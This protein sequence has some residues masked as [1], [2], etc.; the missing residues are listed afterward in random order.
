MTIGVRP[1]RPLFALK[2]AALLLALGAGLAGGA[3]ALQQPAAA[4]QSGPAEDRRWSALW[5]AAPDA[6]PTGAGVYFFRRDIELGGKPSTFP[7]RLSADNRYRLVV[8]GEFVAEGPARGDLLNWNYETL[9]LARHLRSGRNAIAVTVWNFGDLKPA[10]QFSLRTGLLM[11]GLDETSKEVNS[12]TGWKVRTDRAYSFTRVAEADAGGFYVAGPG[13]TIDAAAYPW[14]WETAELSGPGW[15]AAT[16]VG[17]ASRRARHPAGLV[18]N[19]QLVP[20]TIPMMDRQAIRFAAVRRAE[21]VRVPSGFLEGKQALTIPPG[22]S[23]TLLIDN[24][25]MTMG[26]P[27]LRTS[28]GSG[29]E[30]TM[31]YAESLYDGKGNKGDRNVVEGKTI[32]GLRDTI[33][34]DG[35]AARSFT[36]LWLRAFRYVQLEIRTGAEPLRIDDLH[37]LFVAYPFEQKASFESDAAWLKPVWE[38]NW[39]ALRLSAHETFW[40][41]PYYEQL[42]YVGD[43]RIEALMS[44]YQ[45][46]DDRLA[47]NAITQLAQSRTPDGITLSSYPST[48]AQRIPPFSLWWIGMVHDYWMVRPDDDFVKGQLSGVR[49]TLDWYEGLVD[50]TG[51]VGPTPWWPFLDWTADYPGGRPPGADDGH[52]TA[53]SLQLVL[54]LREAADLEDALG[55]KEAALRNRA[56]AD[57]LVAAVRA[58]AWDP[59]RGLFM[60]APEVRRFGQQANALA[61]LADAVPEGQRAAVMTK[62]I[63]DKTLIQASL[64]FRY[65]VDEALQ[66][67][68]MA[69]RYIEG[70]GPWR[71][72]L[73]NGMTST[74]EAPEPSRSDSHAW[75]AH[76]NYHLLATVLGIRPGSPG[77]RSVRIEPALGTLRRASGRMPHPAGIIEVDLRRSG[78]NGLL[79]TVRLP[80]GLA[81]TFRWRDASVPLAGGTNVIACT[82]ICRE[83]G[84]A[85]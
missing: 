42:Q 9:D 55:R 8:N 10:A 37:S 82:D 57:A 68:G 63:E 32:R 48:L 2:R 13:E 19:W 23:A 77:F 25:H 44:I 71:T 30:L 12:G 75:S 70:L 47:R 46:G 85:R 49:A 74:A 17:A 66:R 43:T 41:T 83:A 79:G 67:A 11:E 60:E 24:G 58:R 14:G 20:R 35:G 22:S 50:E 69:D 65:Y 29:A 34:F 31:I 53:F 72:M 73:Q 78:A 56:Q 84:T 6:S 16:V 54:A 36:P 61:I 3:W 1:Q 76:P 38:L 81:G 39:R 28:G 27:V 64:Y 51:M 80:Q 18:L 59:A 5:I 40:D 4:A 15:Q 33:R 45:S 52:N 21:G 26:Y 7:V 62:I